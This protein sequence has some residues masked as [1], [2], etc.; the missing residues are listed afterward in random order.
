MDCNNIFSDV[1]HCKPKTILD[2]RGFFRVN[3]N[4][5]DLENF[6]VKFENLQ[7]NLSFSKKRGTLRGL[8][9]QQKPFE[10]T[11]IIFVLSGEIF[12]VFVDLR[13]SSPTY[14]EYHSLNLNNENGFLI[15]P[16]GFAHGFCTLKD[17]TSVM[18]KV[19]NYYNKK[20]ESGIIWNDQKLSINW[21]VKEDNLIIS[22][23][24]MNLE[25]FDNL[26]YEI[27]NNE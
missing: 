7:D 24:D 3:F 22:D 21:P 5:K 25:A 13:K 15:I 12:D 23:K 4:K 10:Q 26:Q 20:S 9:F 19:D 16:K 18:Y 27:D 14:G 11:K 6:D 17:D 8:H 2:N 1:L